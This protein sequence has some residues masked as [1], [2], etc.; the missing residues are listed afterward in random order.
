MLRTDSGPCDIAQI[1]SFSERPGEQDI[2]LKVKQF[3]PM[4]K[5]D[6]VVDVNEVRTVLALLVLVSCTMTLGST[7]RPV[8]SLRRSSSVPH[9]TKMLRGPPEVV[10]EPSRLAVRLAVSL[11]RILACPR[12]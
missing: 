4:G 3:K 5:V 7:P 8:G 9:S 12:Q 10:K 11:L 6:N 2:R 1:V